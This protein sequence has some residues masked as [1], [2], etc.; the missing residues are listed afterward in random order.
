KPLGIRL[1]YRDPVI[2]EFTLDDHFNNEDNNFLVE[3][4]KPFKLRW[5]V[6][7]AL[8]IQLFR[9]GKLYQKFNKDEKNIT[10][11][12]EIQDRKSKSIEYTLVASNDNESIVS[13]SLDIRF[14]YLNPAINEFTISHY[15]KR[16]GNEFVVENGKPFILQWN[17][18]N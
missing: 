16:E 14:V 11:K 13:K 17:V 2:D 4:G 5:K 8:N 7:N 12:E 3:T 6:Q 18:Q 15:S 9:N 10:L 1:V